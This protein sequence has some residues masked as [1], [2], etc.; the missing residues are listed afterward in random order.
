MSSIGN[1]VEQNRYSTFYES[2][3]DTISS[4][5]GGGQDG[6]DGIGPNEPEKEVEEEAS[7]ASDEESFE[8]DHSTPFFQSLLDY[9]SV[10]FYG[11]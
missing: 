3:Q 10:L 11:K 6:P 1:F 8:Q 5:Q 9:I 4:M 2:L 7:E